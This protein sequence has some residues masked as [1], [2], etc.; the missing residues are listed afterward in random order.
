MATR[1]SARSYRREDVEEFDR[2]MRHFNESLAH[3]ERRML[4]QMIVDALTDADM[5]VSG[6]GEL[7][8]AALFNALTT[9]LLGQA[10]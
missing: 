4:R 3:K 9:Y 1:T 8:D 5:D 6:F 10:E 7:D 2:K